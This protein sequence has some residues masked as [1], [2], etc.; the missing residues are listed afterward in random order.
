MANKGPVLAISTE[1]YTYIK[2]CVKKAGASEVGGL[3]IILVDDDGYPYVDHHRLLKQKV[4]SG[5]VEWDETAHSDYLEWLYKPEEDGG[6]GFTGNEYGLYSWHS[7]GRMGTFFSSTDDDFIKRVGGTAPYLFSS[8]FN[9]SGQQAHRL[10]VFTDLNDIVPLIR[11]RTQIT[12]KD[13]DLY[14]MDSEETSPI[15]TKISAIEEA[16]EESVKQLKEARDADLKDLRSELA[17]LQKGTVKEIEGLVADDFKEFVDMSPSHQSWTKHQ[18]G[19]TAG[20]SN[21]K[22]DSSS[23]PKELTTSTKPASGSGDKGKEEKG[24]AKG[25]DGTEEE[26]GADAIREAILGHLKGIIVKAYDTTAKRWGEYSVS[27]ILSDDDLVP[28]KDFPA[29]LIEALPDEIALILC[30]RPTY[31]EWVNEQMVSDDHLPV[32]RHT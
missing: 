6:A 10:D 21:G 5:E 30:L 32:D 27:D 26:I 13:C 24:E 7:H 28:G 20:G 25:S 12:W 14:V 22:K 1:D 31:E 8:V 17:E 4:S 15:I 9:T 23:S 11:H 29:E 2:A 19:G 16:F 18:P 3:G